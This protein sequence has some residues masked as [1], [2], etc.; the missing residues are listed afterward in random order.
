M[1]SSRITHNHIKYS[2][3]TWFIEDLYNW[4]EVLEKDGVASLTYLQP[5]LS[6]L[7]TLLLYITTILLYNTQHWCWSMN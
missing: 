2:Q 3:L 7:E 1:I 4:Y 6:N 5:L